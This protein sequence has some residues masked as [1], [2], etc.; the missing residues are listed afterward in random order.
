[1]RLEDHCAQALAEFG[2]EFREVQQWLDEFAGRP[3]YGMRHRRVR[4][5]CAGIEEVRRR[6]GAAAAQAAEQHVTADLKEEGWK[7]TDRFPRDAADYV[8]MGL[9]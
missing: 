9:F 2:D 6:W 1:M 5:H 8:R 7:E 4:H 3:G